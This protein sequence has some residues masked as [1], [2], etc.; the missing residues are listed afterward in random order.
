MAKTDLTQSNG[1][2]IKILSGMVRIQGHLGLPAARSNGFD[3]QQIGGRVR[4]VTLSCVRKARATNIRIKMLVENLTCTCATSFP[5]TNSD[6][7][8]L[9]GPSAGA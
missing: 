7:I 5:E 4:L 6:L 9:C 2:A 1:L 3:C 8:D